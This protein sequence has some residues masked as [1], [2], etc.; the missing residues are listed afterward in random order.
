MEIQA[1]KVKQN[2]ADTNRK[3][4]SRE[5]LLSYNVEN[6]DWNRAL[7]GRFNHHSQ[8]SNI[9]NNV[10][11]VDPSIYSVFKMQVTKY[12]AQLMDE[13]DPNCPIRLQ[14]LP[15][16]KEMYS[17]TESDTEID[18]LGEAQDTVPG[19]NLVHRYPNRVLFLVTNTCG[20]Y[21]RYCTRSRLVSQDEGVT[22]NEIE[23]S[24]QYIASN[25]N[26]DDVLLSGGDPLLFP[27]KKLDALLGSI[28]SRAPHVRFL[29]IGS[30]LPVQLPTRITPNLCDI[31]AKHDV[32][33]LNVHINH[34]KEIT[35]LF[36]E[37]IK[38]LRKSGVMLGNQSV[39][40]KGVNDS[41]GVLREL[42]MKCVE[43][44]IRPYYVYANDHV[45]QALH[46]TVSL[47]EMLDLYEGLRGW[48]S[49]PAIP[50]FVVDG[51]GGLGKL[52]V[53][54]SYVEENNGTIKCRNYK[55]ETVN[56]NWLATKETY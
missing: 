6:E 5:D 22:K 2:T 29:R 28:R 32:Q 40:L 55:N 27:D 30:R 3:V 20:S 54:P 24:I 39:L 14:Y 12:V 31:L 33:M 43:I 35:P 34:P 56:M 19:T 51:E 47:K 37:R 23:N 45:T 13:N 1:A 52:P 8:L 9:L 11:D 44:G 4:F 17:A 10:E 18:E 42:C 50:T 36:V 7:V 53:I 49:G 46:F 16:N 48:I 41:V 25:T 26:I 15:T 21:C 38:M